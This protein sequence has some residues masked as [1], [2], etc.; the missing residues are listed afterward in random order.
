[1]QMYIAALAQATLL[2][3]D[4][5]YLACSILLMLYISALARQI[6]LISGQL[7]FVVHVCLH[8]FSLL[9]PVNLLP[10]L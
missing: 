10:L 8:C 4:K 6:I 9:V 3:P 7:S 2:L 5:L 1:M